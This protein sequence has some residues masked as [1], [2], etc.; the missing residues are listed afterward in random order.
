MFV[1]YALENKPGGTCDTSEDSSD[2]SLENKRGDV[3]TASINTF[4]D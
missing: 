3:V 1:D 4:E 2:D